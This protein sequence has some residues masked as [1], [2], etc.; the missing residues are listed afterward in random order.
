MLLGK[1]LFFFVVIHLKE[2][3]FAHHTWNSRP[4]EGKYYSDINRFIH[5]T[6]TNR[7]WVRHAIF[8]YCRLVPSAPD[9]SGIS[10]NQNVTYLDWYSYITN[11]SM[12]NPPTSYADPN[13]R[14]V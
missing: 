14:A 1:E 9:F 2:R 3:A 8:L 6:L 5:S 7:S 4:K 10:S 13:A 11:Y 12:Q